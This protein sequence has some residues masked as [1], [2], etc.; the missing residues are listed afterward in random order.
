M[1]VRSL[2]IVVT[3]VLIKSVE[4]FIWSLVIVLRMNSKNNDKK[5]SVLCISFV[6]VIGCTWN[7]AKAYRIF[8]FIRQRNTEETSILM[9]SIMLTVF[10]FNLKLTNRM[11]PPKSEL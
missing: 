9:E 7:E 4:S 6:E 1:C 10:F 3:F 5:L 8:N 2:Y 11:A